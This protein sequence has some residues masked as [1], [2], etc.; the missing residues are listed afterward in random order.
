MFQ[1]NSCPHWLVSPC[2]SGLAVT[3]MGPRDRWLRV[4]DPRLL[5]L[6]KGASL[7][8]RRLLGRLLTFEERGVSAWGA[9]GFVPTG[10]VGG[11][12]GPSGSGARV[13][14]RAA[15]PARRP[16]PGARPSARPRARRRVSPVSPRA[17][18]PPPLST[19]PAPG[20]TVDVRLCPGS[21]A[22]A[23]GGAVSF[24]LTFRFVAV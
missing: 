18:P 21:R 10:R 22:A 3:W 23:G 1:I 19:R 5:S 15:R 8:S 11:R 17:R 4:Q 9:P 14:R 6:A 20:T 12:L 2:W 16:V 7:S 24:K 13:P